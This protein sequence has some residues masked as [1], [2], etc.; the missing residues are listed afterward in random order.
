[1]K[2]VVFLF[3]AL[4]LFMCVNTPA[5]AGD[6]LFFETDAVSQEARIQH[7]L[8]EVAVKMLNGSRVDKIIPVFYEPGKKG[9][10]AYA[11]MLS[12]SVHIQKGLI[13]FI[14]NE[15]ELAAVTAHEIAHAT[16]YHKSMLQFIPMNFNPKAYE[17][18]ADK[19]GVDL[20]VNGGYNPLG[21]ITLY[22]K[23]MH[24]S[25][26]DWVPIRSSHPKTSRRL[27]TIYEYIYMKYPQYLANNAYKDNIYYQN[28][29]LTSRDNR[30]RF[31]G[32]AKNPSIRVR[33]K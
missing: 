13:R 19:M 33:Y 9:V 26:I 6:Q 21:M 14:E 29:L 22:S 32:K 20:M 15:D 25:Y 18:K 16:E 1:M 30:K 7:K 23:F 17:F 10:N 3:A 11:Y 24:Q 27:A 5:R 28:F 31:E 8:N 4:L 2:K 12:K